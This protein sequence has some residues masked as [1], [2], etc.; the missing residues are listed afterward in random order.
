[1]L[2]RM[3]AKYSAAV[4]GASGYLGA[5]VLRRL[6]QHPHV[7]VTRAFAADHLGE[8]LGAA[9]SNLEGAS[10]LVFEEAPSD[11]PGA[12][13]AVLMALPHEA[14]WRVVGSLLQSNTRV[15]DLSGAFRLRTAEQYRTRYGIDHP[16]PELLS[17]F[18]YGLPEANRG[19][20]RGARFVANPGCFATTLELSLLPLARA[21]WLSGTAR[22]VAVTGSSGSGAT[23]SLGTHHPIRDGNLR[24]YRPLAHPHAPE[25][26]ETLTSAGASNFRLDFVPVS[27]PLVRGILATTFVTLETQPS[28]EDVEGAYASFAAAEPFCRVP[29]RRLPEVVAVAGS[30]YAEVAIR[31]D[32]ELPGHWVCFGALDNLIKGGAGQAIQNLNLMLDLDETTGLT[33]V[34]GFP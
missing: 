10:D 3:S 30:N 24:P 12:V 17:E 9:H 19:R 33:D 32:P 8:P 27:G 16:F 26:A 1:M 20:L 15:I 28:T 11:G 2:Q 31:Q 13:D 7:E 18:V 25:V 22:A 5:E 6:L 29:A 21:G 23:P 4:Y 14:S 34:G